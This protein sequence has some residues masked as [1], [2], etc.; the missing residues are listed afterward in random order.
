MITFGDELHHAVLSM[1]DNQDKK[2][3]LDSFTFYLKYGLN[4]S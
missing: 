2:I 1:Q 4:K 3:I